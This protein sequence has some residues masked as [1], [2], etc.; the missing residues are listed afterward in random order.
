MSFRRLASLVR[1]RGDLLS[2]LLVA[3]LQVATIAWF[4]PG[5]GL[6]LDDA[7]IHQVVGR[8]F[9]ETGTLGYAP[10][11]HGAAATS[12]L[13]AALLALNFEVLHVDPTRWALL[14]NGAATLTTGQLLHSLVLRARP[15]DVDRLEW[16]VTSLVT[17]LLASISPNLLWFT[18]SGMEAMPFVALSLTAIWAATDDAASMRRATFAGFAAGALALLRPEAAPLG[19]LLAVHAF[20]RKRHRTIAP[21]AA[22]WIVCVAV[23]VGSNVA[24]TGHALPSTLAGRRW[25]WFETSSGLSR[26]V[27]ALDFLDAWTTRLGTYTFDT[28][29]TVVWI[30]IALAAYGAV[31]LVRTRASVSHDGFRLL[32][33]WALFHAAFY[34]LLLPTPGHGGR[35]QPLTPLLFATCLPLGVALLLREIGR[36]VGFADKVGFAWFAALGA[37]PWIALATPVAQALRHDN[38][39]AVAHIQGTELAAGAFVDQLPE[40]AVA[41]FDIGGIGWASKRRVLDLGGLSDPKTA[42]VLES[43]RISTWLEENRVR[44]IVLPQSYEPTLPV[45]EDYRTRLHLAENP[46]LRIEPVR[47]FETPFDKWEPS[48]RST[49]NAAP[50]QVVYEVRYTNLPGPREVPMDA[51]DALRSIPDP[52]RLVP[53]RERV[54]AEHMLAMLAV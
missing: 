50:K 14:L 3:A 22:P 26:G 38:A 46:S 24:K 54:V 13:W 53:A 44:W 11:Q 1:E 45:F 42:T 9:A 15:S 43:G 40:G 39:L 16:H 23:Y 8:T 10:G 17:T 19:G 52:A 7:W 30:L 25:L 4:S 49:W 37:A 47:S 48:I 34:A 5:R 33:V 18:C 31:R 36:L 41:S 51:P 12:Y 28:G 29:L 32:V 35:Y 27:R 21:I 20:L 6:P 2:R